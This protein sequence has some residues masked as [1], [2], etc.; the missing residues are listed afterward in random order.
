MEKI[1]KTISVLL[2]SIVMIGYFAI[3]TNSQNEGTLGQINAALGVANGTLGSINGTL[4]GLKAT[5]NDL[6]D[7][8]KQM[9]QDS[10]E[11]AWLLDVKSFIDLIQTISETVCIFEK[12]GPLM[13]QNGFATGNCLV[14]ANYNYYMIDLNAAMDILMSISKSMKSM[15]NGERISNFKQALDLM[16]RVT[17]GLG[18]MNIALMRAEIQNRTAQKMQQSRISIAFVGQRP[19]SYVGF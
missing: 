9:K 15:S 10:Q 13:E 7:V 5:M 8:Q 1:H 11:F 2:L 18:M 19:Q 4:G 6:V 14:M 3:P 12:L 16:R 17:K